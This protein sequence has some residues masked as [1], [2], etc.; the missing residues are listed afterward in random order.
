MGFY[1]VNP[2]GGAFVIGSPLFDEVTISLPG[3][4]EFTIKSV[5]NSDQNMYIQSAKLNGAIYTRSYITYKEIMNG[6]TLEFAMGPE[7]NYQFG[8][9]PDDRPKSEIY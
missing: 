9:E 4:K 7:P 5:N 8:A 6:G 1:P 2:A 3:N